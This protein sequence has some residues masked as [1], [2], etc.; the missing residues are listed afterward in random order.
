MILLMPKLN[1]LDNIIFNLDFIKIEYSLGDINEALKE[2]NC[3]N[4][5]I[6]WEK[7]MKKFKERIKKRV[8]CFLS[9]Y[10]WDWFIDC[11]TKIGK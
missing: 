6:D 11:L 7:S 10:E 1:Y 3:N 2:L 5:E 4:E 9:E 8:K